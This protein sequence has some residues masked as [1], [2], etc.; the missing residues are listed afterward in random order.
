MQ[1]VT[2]VGL[3]LIGAS[4]G[5]GLRRWSTN[6]GKRQPVLSVTGFDTNLEHQNY[7]K[8][9]KAVDRTE[10]DLPKAIREADMVIV[11]VPPLAVRGVFESL[12]QD[13]KPGAVVTDVTSTKADIMRW[14]DEILPS[15]AHFIGGHPMAG[16][17]Q[18][19]EGAEADLFQNATWCVVPSVRADEN[20]VQTVLGMVSALGADPTFVDAH[21]HDGFVGAVS[22][23]PFMLSIALMNSVSKDPAWRDMKL[24]SSTGFQD[25]S[26]LAGGSA[27]MHR[28]ICV[29]NREAVVRWMDVAIEEMLYMRSL[30]SAGTEETDEKLLDVFENARDARA[31]WATSE[32]RGGELVQDTDSELSNVSMAGQ[33]NQMLFGSMLRRKPRL[34]SDSPEDRRNGRDKSKARD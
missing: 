31:S 7:A 23:L 8:K 34:G 26:R 14:A 19:I 2:I 17:A 9:I 10:W 15:T 5:L 29:T 4:I 11:A 1:Q 33:F 21:E 18:S 12:S 16:K 6:D 22:H 20:A 25:V 28:D 24:L 30:I 27:E 32:R 3:G 13:L